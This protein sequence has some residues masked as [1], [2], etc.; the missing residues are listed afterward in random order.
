M[1]KH[2]FD[3]AS[4]STSKRY[5]FEIF[6]LLFV[7]L[8]SSNLV[9]CQKFIPLDD[10]V[11]EFIPTVSFDLFY[12]KKLLQT[13]L[14]SRDTLTILDAAVVFDSIHFRKEGFRSKG[15]LKD[16]L[17]EVVFLQKEVFELDE[18][19][20][21]TAVKKETFLGENSRFVRKRSTSFQA[22]PTAG[23]MFFREEL[24]TI[25]VTKLRFFVEKVSVKTNYKI[26]FYA[27]ELVGSILT[28]N[29]VKIGAVFF[30]SPVLQ[31]E[32]EIKNEVIVDLESGG[33]PKPKSNLFVVIELVS[34]EDETGQI[35]SPEPNKLTKLK[36]QL[37]KKMNYF[38]KLREV[39]THSLTTYFININ[40]MIRRDFNFMFKKTPHRSSL[41]TPAIS[42]YGAGVD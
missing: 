2:H 9:V 3:T 14:T 26:K 33:F 12:K 29:E 18:V 38:A 22:E 1:I 37:S 24:A 32:K 5:R 42:L 19:V 41:V 10:D 36:Y 30:E 16:S 40:A 20:L 35:I 23:I 21:N 25:D 13:G 11:M 6:F 39:R 28:H 15:F 34:Y 17:P 7:F 31:L 4:K 8:L 27:C